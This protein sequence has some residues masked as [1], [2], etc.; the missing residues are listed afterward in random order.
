MLN[1][2]ERISGCEEVR[3]QVCEAVSRGPV[4]IRGD[5]V[6][7]VEGSLMIANCSDRRPGSINL[8]KARIGEAESRAAG[9]VVR[10]RARPTSQNRSRHRYQTCPADQ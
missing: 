7:G 6:A 5:A 1:L 2:P 8:P 3:Y 9:A 10:A 4:E